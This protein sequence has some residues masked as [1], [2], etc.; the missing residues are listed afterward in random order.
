MLEMKVVLL[1][2]FRSLVPPLR[3]VYLF[4]SLAIYF[5]IYYGL[6]ENKEGL[7]LLKTAIAKAGY[8]GK[9]CLPSNYLQEIYHFRLIDG[10]FLFQFI[11][12]AMWQVVIG[13]DVAASEFYNEK[14]H[15]Y[16]LNFKEEVNCAF[17][18]HKLSSLTCQR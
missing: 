7:E 1:P 8:T 4:D 3:V 15:T 9:V 16:D 2:I 14:D 6:Q 18:D 13:M 10:L 17:L 5:L 11:S 12:L